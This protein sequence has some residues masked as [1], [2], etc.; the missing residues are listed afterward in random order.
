MCHMQG[1]FLGE[2]GKETIKQEIDPMG[3]LLE[4][5]QDFLYLS[6]N[7]EPLGGQVPPY[8]Y[9][10]TLW[11]IRPFDKGSKDTLLPTV[12]SMQISTIQCKF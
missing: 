5:H 1:D 11:Y 2:M 8:P 6:P 10:A 7:L 4:N 9:L 12:Q 3:F